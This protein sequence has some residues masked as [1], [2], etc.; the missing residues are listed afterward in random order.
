MNSSADF[1]G[2]LATGFTAAL[3][4]IVNTALQLDAESLQNL[5]VFEGKVIQIK[6]QG[7][8]LD[9]YLQPS[10]Q[11]VILLNHYAGTADAT[12][13]G[14]PMKFAEMALGDARKVLF[15][16]DVTISGDI[17]LGQ[18]FKRWMDGLDIDWEEQLSKVTGDIVAHK[19]GNLLRSATTWGLQAINIL[20]QNTA[21]YLKEES[22]QLPFAEEMDDFV[23]QVNEFRDAVAR[24]EVRML[25]LKDKVSH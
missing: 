5:H 7:L 16:G 18:N 22:E 10:P 11:G 15:S 24:L 4:L 8:E 19:A 12:L 3:E 2:E 17:E 13:A 20:S 25:Q 21:D 23:Q 6:L 14:R 9:F 1:T